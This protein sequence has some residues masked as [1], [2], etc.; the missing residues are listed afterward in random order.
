MPTWK[1]DIKLLKPWLLQ[2]IKQRMETMYSHLNSNYLRQILHL[3][4]LCN[5]K[6]INTPERDFNLLLNLSKISAVKVWIEILRKKTDKGL[7]VQWT[8]LTGRIQCCSKTRFDQKGWNLAKKQSIVRQWLTTFL[9]IFK[10]QLYFMTHHLH[11][12]LCRSTQAT[13]SRGHMEFHLSS[14]QTHWF[15]NCYV[16]LC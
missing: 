13:T 2:W 11:S 3:Y 14:Q 5:N 8:K 9:H 10:Q 12:W 1:P 7:K 16:P 4:N 15:G 6:K